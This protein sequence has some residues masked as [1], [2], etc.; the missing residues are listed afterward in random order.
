VVRFVRIAAT[1]MGVLLAAGGASAA[2]RGLHLATFNTPGSNTWPV[3]SG[4][5]RA[6]VSL[7]GVIGLRAGTVQRPIRAA[8]ATPISHVVVIDMENHSFDN[9]LGFWCDANPNRCPHGGMPTS[10]TLS[11]GATLTPSVDPDTIPNVLH[12]VGSQVAAM[13]NVD[14]VPRMDG[15]QN[16]PDG[17][18]AASTNYQCVSGYLPEQIPNLTALAQHFGI[19]DDTF[20]MAAAPSWGGHLYAVMASL[21]HFTGDNPVPAPGVTAGPGW[22]CDSDK[23]TPWRSSTGTLELIPSCIPDFKLGVANGGAFEPT[24]AAYHATIMDELDKAG[25]T[26]K[27]YGAPGTKDG[28][29]LWSV[30][31]SIAE[32][33]YTNQNTRLVEAS[34][35]GT[36]ASTGHLPSFSLVVSGGAGHLTLSS[37]H[38]KFSMTACDNYIGQLVSSIEQGPAWPSTAIFITFDD[39]G[40]FYDQVP[41]PPNP[42]GT[43][44]GPRLPLIIVS[45]YARPGYTDTTSS[46]FAGILAYV[47][48]N[49]GLPSLSLKDRSAYDFHNAFNYSQTPLKPIPLRPRPLPASARHI[50][51]SAIGKDPS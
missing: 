42:D 2:G 38:N 18:C 28:G 32:C 6:K 50:H 37:C 16:I 5:K 15:W 24:P 22:G 31:P 51:A 49:F 20:S 33:H 4:V 1:A 7:A 3:P 41:P 45:P 19:S 43:Q 36:D 34:Q 48:H 9:V 27:I 23:I 46:S 17:S 35:F 13:H 21:D 11:N 25:L 39:F 26:W 10:V 12:T 8:T 40:G 14:G 47:E 44:E 29:Y 30:C